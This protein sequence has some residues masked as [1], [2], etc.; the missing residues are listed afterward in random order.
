MNVN[1]IWKEFSAVKR[2]FWS[3]LRIW[4]RSTA[5]SPIQSSFLFLENCRI[6][7]K[8][9]FANNQ[10]FNL[11]KIS[12]FSDQQQCIW[13]KFEHLT[14][15]GCFRSSQVKLE[16]F[17]LFNACH[18]LFL[19]NYRIWTMKMQFANNQKFNLIQISYFSYQ[20]QCIWNILRQIWASN[21]FWLF[22]KFTS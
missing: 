22:Q 16:Y 3:V 17:S 18:M 14:L 5:I 15:P 2:F 9:P 19:E 7:T 4:D 1:T 10:K 8:M 12:Y 6:S 13:D 20:Q 21:S 11:I